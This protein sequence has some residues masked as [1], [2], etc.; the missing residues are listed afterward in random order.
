[1]LV[2]S[3]GKLRTVG[4]CTINSHASLRYAKKKEFLCF[5]KLM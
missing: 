1:M 2:D 5:L 3:K 4:S